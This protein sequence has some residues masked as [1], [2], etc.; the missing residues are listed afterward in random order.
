MWENLKFLN[1]ERHIHPDLCGKTNIANY[2]AMDWKHSSQLV[3]E[4]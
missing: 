2:G 1:K 3:G 4:L